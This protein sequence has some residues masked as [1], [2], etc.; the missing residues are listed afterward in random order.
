M[1]K[2]IL[3]NNN[4]L[5]N[6]KTLQCHGVI[7]VHTKVKRLA[8]AAAGFHLHPSSVATVG[9]FAPAYTFKSSN[10][11]Y[12]DKMHYYYYTQAMRTYKE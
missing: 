7:I 12:F 11:S 2:E 4:N 10:L 3:A 5:R 9:S 6:K 1:Q 8:A